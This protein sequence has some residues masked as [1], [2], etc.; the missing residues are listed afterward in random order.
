[1]V[2][3]VPIYLSEI[4]APQTRG[5]IGG[6][7]G[8]GIVFGIMVANWVGFACSYAPY[9]AVQWRLPLAIQIPWGV[10]LFI[11]LSTFMPGSPRELVRKGK[12][13]EARREFLKIRQDLHSHQIHEEF[14][15]MRSQIQF[16]LQREGISYREIWKL[17]RHRVSVYVAMKIVEARRLSARLLTLS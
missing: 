15:L 9:G 8:L 13:D 3:T 16:E 10:L 1:L 6:I 17:Y 11:G 7:S 12:V 4:S 2:G 14:A 5:L